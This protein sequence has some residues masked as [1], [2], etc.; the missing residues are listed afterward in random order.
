MTQYD[1]LNVKLSYSQLNKIKSVIKSGTKVTLDL[2]S[3][4]VGKSID[5][6][7]FSHKL[8]LTNKQVSRIHKAFANVSSAIINFS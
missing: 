7:I 8:L 4:V 2:P 3:N 5:E 6:T 1:I